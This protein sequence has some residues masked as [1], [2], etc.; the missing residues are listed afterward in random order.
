MKCVSYCFRIICVNL[1][2]I[3]DTLSLSN[4]PDFKI[5]K[6]IPFQHFIQFVTYNIEEKGKTYTH[7]TCVMCT[8][9]QTLKSAVCS[10][11]CIYI[12]FF[13]SDITHRKSWGGKYLPYFFPYEISFLCTSWVIWLYVW[14]LKSS[15][16][17]HSA[18]EKWD[19]YW[20][21][22]FD[23]VFNGIL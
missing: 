18:M 14:L 23:F 7:I 10:G 17:L 20:N 3:S 15:L 8:S 12:D 22:A 2:L 4:F 6:C 1:K 13:L 16:A 21:V 11:I 5:F 19:F 9:D